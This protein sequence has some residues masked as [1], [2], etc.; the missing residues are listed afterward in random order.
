MELTELTAPQELHPSALET[1]SLREDHTG[2]STESVGDCTYQQVKGPEE[3]SHLVREPAW[4]ECVSHG[5][6][7]GDRVQGAMRSHWNINL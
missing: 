2:M 6:G 5:E 4:L 3:G 7:C 1:D